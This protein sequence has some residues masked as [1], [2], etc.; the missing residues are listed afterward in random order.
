MTWYFNR[1]GETRGP[2]DEATFR[3]EVV[4][5]RIY[6]SDMLWQ[7]GWPD[8]RE[9]SK[10]EG[11]FIPPPINRTPQHMPVDSRGAA[12]SA[13]ASIKNEKPKAPQVAPIGLSDPIRVPTVNTNVSKLQIRWLTFYTYIRLPVGALGLLINVFSGST[14]GDIAIVSILGAALA[15]CVTIGLHKNRVWGWK[16][17]WLQLGSEA[18]FF[19]IFYGPGLNPGEIGVGYSF[20]YLLIIIV[21][22][23]LPNG[24]YFRKRRDL[25]K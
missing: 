8:W 10:V 24:I 13:E 12:A 6:A 19:A 25:F 20:L 14:S 17:N 2:L 1:D 4:A 22:W 18:L 21:V 16:L 7:P 5:G 15:I 3:A 9:A 11:V 23:V